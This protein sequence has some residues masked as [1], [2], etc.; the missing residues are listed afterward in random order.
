V[1]LT[2]TR[3]RAIALAITVLVLTGLLVL[4]LGP[5]RA[6]REDLASM[7]RNVAEQLDEVTTQRLLTDELVDRAGRLIELAE[8]LEQRAARLE[9]QAG[10]IE[11]LVEIARKLDVRSAELLDIARRSLALA[12]RQIVLSERGIDQVDESLALQRA[13][14]DVARQTL[15]E[16]R[17]INDKIPPPT[18]GGIVPGAGT[19][20]P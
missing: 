2:D 8:T 3:F 14:L 12:E 11:E 9:E 1:Q 10:G 13:G 16:V 6:A 7:D 15:Q 19:A 17:E 5:G 18:G 4:L 20:A